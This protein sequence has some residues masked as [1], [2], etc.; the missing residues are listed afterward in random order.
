MDFK[1]ILP[2]V[3]GA[4]VALIVYDKLIKKFVGSFESDYDE[5]ENE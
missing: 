2:V 4:L 5:S 1:A 3:I